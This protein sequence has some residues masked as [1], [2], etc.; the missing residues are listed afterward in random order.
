MLRPNDFVAH[1]V[2]LPMMTAAERQVNSS[3]T[4]LTMAR[5]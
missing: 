4:F 2:Q 5:G 1:P 3:L